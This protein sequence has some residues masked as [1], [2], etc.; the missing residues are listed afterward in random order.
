MTES[1]HLLD[2]ITLAFETRASLL[3]DEDTNVLR[4]F[5]G[6][7]EGFPGLA[8]DLY[9]STLVLFD[10]RKSVPQAENVLEEIE[11]RYLSLLPR[12]DCVIHKTRSTMDPERKMGWISRGS[13]PVREIRESGLRYAVSLL[14]NQDASF[15][16][17]TRL[18]R[19]WLLKNSNG[20]R[21]FNTFAYTGSLG[22][23][24]L[25]GG[26]AQ[27]IQ[28]DRNRNFLELA[29]TSCML[30]RLD[31]GRMKLTA[32]DFFSG[33]SQLKKSGSLFDL[34]IVD[35]PYFSVTEKGT[36]NQ[37]EESSRVINKI[38]PL[39]RD[40]GRILTVNNSLFLSGEDYFLSL[41]ALCADGY[42]EIESLIP[43]P[44][45]VTGYPGT[46]VSQPHV[47]PAPFNHS[48]K[49]AVLRVKRKG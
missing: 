47:S 10:Y 35:P 3:N 48:T 34:V 32:D 15:Y 27:V 44:E 28:L 49:I 31:L 29:R 19:K 26:A 46:M 43:V 41:S 13:N 42:L 4:L 1:I 33:V 45:D 11:T 36:I 16:I 12:V 17:D 21:V 2:R 37:V 5:S 40:G 38:R 22:V 9:G 18:L 20:L 23:A 7:Y 39:V 14:M 30:N 25:A 6:F 24:S 8:A